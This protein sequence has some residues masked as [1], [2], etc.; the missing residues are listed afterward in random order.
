MTL[1]RDALQVAEALDGPEDALDIEIILYGEV[2]QSGGSVQ[3]KELGSGI[4]TMIPEDIGTKH[5]REDKKVAIYT[6]IQSAAELPSKWREASL[7]R[8]RALL[9]RVPKSVQKRLICRCVGGS[10]SLRMALLC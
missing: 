10:L 8:L 1:S 2:V 3:I 5:M 7:P 6:Q 9:A 4:T